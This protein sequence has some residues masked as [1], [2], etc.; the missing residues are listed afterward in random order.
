ME[1]CKSKQVADILH[2]MYQYFTAPPSGPLHSLTRYAWILNSQDYR[3]ANS[4]EINKCLVRFI[5]LE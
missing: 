3:G 2:A 1:K 4:V 5:Q